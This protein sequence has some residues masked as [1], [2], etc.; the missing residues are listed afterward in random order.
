M[1][2]LFIGIACILAGGY[3]FHIST[4]SGTEMSTTEKV[5][6]II[7][8]VACEY[9]GSMCIIQSILGLNFAQ[10]GDFIISLFQ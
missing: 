6:G 9:Y 8:A 2:I 4:E 7:T 10:Q 5:G 3:F 1:E